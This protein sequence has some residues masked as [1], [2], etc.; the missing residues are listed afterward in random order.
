MSRLGALEEAAHA[1]GLFVSGVAPLQPRDGLPDR[2]RSVALL[3]PD[4]PRFWT[5]FSAS[6]ERQDGRPDALDRWSRRVIGQL[7]CKLGTKAA[8]PFAGPP[9]RPFTEWARRSGR[10]WPS[11]V[12]LLVHDAA[13]LWISYRGAI[14]LEEDARPASLVQPCEN[15]EARPCLNACPVAA[16]SRDSYDVSSCHDVLDSPG[17]QSCLSSG[18]RVRR[19]CPRGAERRLPAQSAFHMEAFH[20]A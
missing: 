16:L 6:E 10:A 12:G 3:S 4:E 18:C 8:F 20:P 17:G 11:P 9:W 15:C 5:I 2:F 13:G 7:A 19:A 14:A 1:H